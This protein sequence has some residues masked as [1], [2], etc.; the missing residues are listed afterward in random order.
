MGCW[1]VILMENEGEQ[2]SLGVV[3]SGKSGQLV[4]WFDFHIQNW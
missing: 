2:A 4:F 3:Y 1:V